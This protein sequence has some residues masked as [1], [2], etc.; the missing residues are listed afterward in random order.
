MEKLSPVVREAFGIRSARREKGYYLC[1]ADYDEGG[2]IKV[3]ITTDT[4]ESIRLQHSVKEHLAIKGF[5]HTN[6]Y[7]LTKTGQPFITIGRETYVAVIQPQGQHELDFDNDNAVLMAFEALARFHIAGINMPQKNISVAI[8]LPEVYA[9]QLGEL[10]QA[11]K[12]A[13]RVS[14][15]SD[16]DVA[17]IKHSPHTTKTIQHAIDLLEKTSYSSLFSQA[18]AQTTLCHNVLKEEN[19]QTTTGATYI[20]NFAQSS[21]D[22]Q[23]TDLAALIRRYAQRSS[24]NIPINRLVATYDN[25]YPLPADAVDILRAQLIFPWSFMKLVNQYYSKKRNWA[26]N[27][28]HNRMDTILSERESYENYIEKW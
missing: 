26:P 5:P 10:A 8:P 13:R 7:K 22:H 17:F 28:L 20:N 24:R 21:I 3:H 25:I 27:G 15:M 1:N 9:R 18:V 16:F 11:G 19:I 14:R 12:Q 23:A 4:A 2:I 6:R